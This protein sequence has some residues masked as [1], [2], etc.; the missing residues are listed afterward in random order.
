MRFCKECGTQLHEKEQFCRKCGTPV[1]LEKDETK[2]E[3][4][5]TENETSTI[6]PTEK[7]QGGISQDQSRVGHGKNTTPRK[8]MSKKTKI[9]LS[10]SLVLVIGFVTTYFILSSVYTEDKAVEKFKQAL[11]DQDAKTLADMIY[12]ENTDMKIDKDTIGGFLDFL[13]KNPSYKDELVES[14]K[15]QATSIKNSG[16]EEATAS[17]SVMSLTKQGKKLLL[18]D[19]FKFKVQPYY[20]TVSTNYKDTDLYL[21]DEKVATA[22]TDDFTEELGPFLPGLYQV[23][24]ELENDYATFDYEEE[25]VLFDETSDDYVDVDMEGH[26]VDVEADNNNGTLLVNGEKTD[27]NIEEDPSFGPVPLDGSVT[28]QA[29]YDYP[30]DEEVT[31]D[32]IPVEDSYV[33]IEDL[34]VSKDLKKALMDTAND[35]VE[36]HYEALNNLDADKVRN[37]SDSHLKEVKDTIDYIK[38]M[39]S[40]FKGVVHKTIFDLDSFTLSENDGIYEATVAFT[41]VSE[42][43]EYGEEDK[44]DL[45]D[46]ETNAELE[47]IFDESEDTWLVD[48]LYDTY[49][50]DDAVNTEEFTLG[51]GAD[52]ENTSSEEDAKDDEA[53]EGDLSDYAAQEI[54]YAR[55]WLEVNGDEGIDTLSVSF[56]SSG[57]PVHSDD[58]ESADYPEDVIQLAADTGDIVTYSGNGDGTLNLYAV[59]SEWDDI[60]SDEVVDMTNQIIDDTELV[61]IDPN[62]DDAVIN[63][64]DKLDINE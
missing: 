57:E 45:S 5:V 58:D 8:P 10:T 34:P 49:Y 1:S 41:V 27:L 59:P 55:V 16:A 26:T 44:P 53:A 60:P 62:D 22:D 7:T 3:T 43:D 46:E 63:L 21:N 23:R 25:L 20:F 51:E 30:W 61:S 35:Y 40:R 50:S 52:G 31:S 17:S 13:D 4:P 14:L 29:Q 24:A 2:R 11:S 32:E 28:V 9:L 56:L 33:Y 15:D 42:E 38:E 36:S 19:D 64:I 48:E 47:F 37:I 39:D 6:T 18:F 12:S 54:E